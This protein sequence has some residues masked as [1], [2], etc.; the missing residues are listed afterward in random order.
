MEREVC[1]VFMHDTK[2]DL[3][4]VFDRI[5]KLETSHAVT[6]ERDKTLLEK[7]DGLKDFFEKHDK[8]EM[9]KYND[10]NK[11]VKQL[12][13]FMYIATGI[14]MV[15]GFVGIDNIKLIFGG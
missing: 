10:I 7:M 4:E 8:Q 2:R 12:T 9:A 15:L 3:N 13:T 6:K 14:S 11:D 5:R 1:T